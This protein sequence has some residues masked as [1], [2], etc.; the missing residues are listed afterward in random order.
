MT[1]LV[2]EKLAKLLKISIEQAEKIAPQLQNEVTAEAVLTMIVAIAGVVFGLSLL[3]VAIMETYDEHFK[4]VVW[5]V[6]ISM[7]VLVLTLACWKL[8]TP[9]LNLIEKFK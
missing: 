1:H 6:R 7:T 9:T 8:F 5:V 2:A 3:L 4:I